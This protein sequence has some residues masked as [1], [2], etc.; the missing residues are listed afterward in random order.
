MSVRLVNPNGSHA[1]TA[2]MVGIAARVLPGVVGQT[3]ADMPPML[4][5]PQELDRAADAV[6][7]LSFGP[8]VDGVIVAA[9]GDPGAG[10]LA[11]RIGVP[12]PVIG[13]GAA[14]ARAAS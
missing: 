11:A 13:I 3:L 9:F 4:V 2:Q 7:A 12:V 14:A 10:A 8:E 6:A 5:T 1:V